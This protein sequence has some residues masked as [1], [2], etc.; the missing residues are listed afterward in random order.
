MCWNEASAGPNSMTGVRKLA[1]GI[2]LVRAPAPPCNES[3]A[4]AASHVSDERAIVRH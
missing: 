2:I 4:N 3:I 1:W